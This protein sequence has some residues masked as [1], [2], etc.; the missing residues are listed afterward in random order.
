MV[1]KFDIDK[2]SELEGL[3]EERSDNA[4]RNDNQSNAG[5][6]FSEKMYQNPGY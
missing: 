2:F 3:D 1:K 6:S 4:G 5:E